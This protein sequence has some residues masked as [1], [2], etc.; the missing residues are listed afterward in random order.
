MKTT[1]NSPLPERQRN[2][3][4]IALAIYMVASLLALPAQAVERSLKIYAPTRAKANLSI[5]VDVRAS[6]DAGAGEQIGFIQVEVSADGGKTWT[7]IC[8]DQ[9]LG[10]STVRHLTAKTGEA[11]TS[12]LIRAKAA[13]RGGVAGDVDFTGTAINWQDSWV[14]WSTPPARMVHIEIN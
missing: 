11:G 4:P 3:I 10:P 1:D 12:T 8:F 5:T 13:Y 6:T 14:E 7:A 9:D 2:R